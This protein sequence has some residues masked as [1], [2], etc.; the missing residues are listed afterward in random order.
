LYFRQKVNC[1]FLQ[2]LPNLNHRFPRAV[3]GDEKGENLM[4]RAFIR[5]FGC[6]LSAIGLSMSYDTTMTVVLDDEFGFGGAYA[7]P[8]HSI[9]QQ[10]STGGTGTGLG[11]VYS[12]GTCDSAEGLSSDNYVYKYYRL[13]V[14]Y[15]QGMLSSSASSD[16]RNN[17]WFATYSSASLS[18]SGSTLGVIA[19]TACARNEAE[20]TSGS[21][22]LTILSGFAVSGTGVCFTLTENGRSMIYSPVRAFF[23]NMGC[24]YVSAPSG[25]Q[26]WVESSSGIEPGTGSGS[27]TVPTANCYYTNGGDYSKVTLELIEAELL[28]CNKEAYWDSSTAVSSVARDVYVIEPQFGHGKLG[29]S[30]KYSMGDVP[31]PAC[32][33]DTSDMASHPFY[34]NLEDWNDYCAACPNY[35]KTSDLS[36][37][38]N[39]VYKSTGGTGISS[40]K[41]NL[42][43]TDPKGNFRYGVDCA[44]SQ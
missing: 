21:L 23:K 14:P 33:L 3:L 27:G 7:A 37:Y 34:T 30:Y 35:A 26:T 22:L 29:L 10:Y 19:D 16:F 20:Y 31:N 42:D 15:Y 28:R 18:W 44:Y 11:Y 5:L 40:C 2:K 12:E 13:I 32:V 39:L 8:T 38:T 41:I 1:I 17:V 43:G 24:Q 6:V 4:K 25:L 9:L 36:S